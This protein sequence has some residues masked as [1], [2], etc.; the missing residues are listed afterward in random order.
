MVGWSRWSLLHRGKILMELEPFKTD[1]I[2]H[3]T[4]LI[5]T[6]LEMKWESLPLRALCLLLLILVGVFLRRFKALTTE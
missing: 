1:N 4:K 5:M 6:N 2:G 3:L